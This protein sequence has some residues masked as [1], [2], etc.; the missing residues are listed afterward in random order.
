MTA[1]VCILYTI[2]LPYSSTVLAW[3]DIIVVQSV[4]LIQR[5][6][7][8]PHTSLDNIPVRYCTSTVPVKIFGKSKIL[9]DGNLNMVR[10]QVPV[11]YLV[12]PTLDYKNR[13]SNVSHDRVL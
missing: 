12:P 3:Y 10:Y 6:Q 8:H 4:G 1:D 11:T 2:R 5:D 9:S 13:C 7:I